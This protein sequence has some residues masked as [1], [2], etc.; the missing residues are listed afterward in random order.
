MARRYAHFFSIDENAS[1]CSTCGCTELATCKVS[2]IEYDVASN[3]AKRNEMRRKSG[4]TKLPQLF[5]NGN[6]LGVSVVFSFWLLFVRLLCLLRY[7][8]R[9]RYILRYSVPLHLLRL[10]AYA[11]SFCPLPPLSLL[12]LSRL[13]LTLPPS[14]PC[15]CLAVSHLYLYLLH[16]RLLVL[17]V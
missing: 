1:R 16:T 4:Q 17:L 6:Y 14:L 3:E 8:S 10:F 5:I 12:S 9:T 7:I 11:C 13:A 15:N 2:Y